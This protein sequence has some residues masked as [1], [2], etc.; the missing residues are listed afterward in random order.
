MYLY[1]PERPSNRDASMC[2]AVPHVVRGSQEG[3]GTAANSRDP[4][5]LEPFLRESQVGASRR[6][7]RQ[8]KRS[9]SGLCLSSKYAQVYVFLQ[10]ISVKSIAASH[11]LALLP[12]PT[13]ATAKISCAFASLSAYAYACAHTHPCA[14]SHPPTHSI[15]YTCPGAAGRFCMTRGSTRLSWCSKA[16]TASPPNAACKLPRH[17]PP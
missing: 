4:R 5:S 9:C 15:H 3:R 11:L 12:L 13:R 16:A 7:Q 6:V 1:H 8:N 17:L 14:Y 2:G 10:N